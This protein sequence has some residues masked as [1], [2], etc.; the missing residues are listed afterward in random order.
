M[1]DLDVG[2]EVTNGSGGR[3]LS[4]FAL[5]GWRCRTARRTIGDQKLKVAD[6]M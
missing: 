6:T 5:F 3:R 1:R 4:R 2:I